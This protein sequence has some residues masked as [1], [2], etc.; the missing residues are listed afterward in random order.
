[1]T[2]IRSI[3]AVVPSVRTVE[4]GGFPVRRPFPTQK[5]PLVDPFLLLDEMGPVDWAPGRAIGAPD[6]PHRGFETVTY[7]LEGKVVHRDSHG[8]EAALGPGDVQWMTAGSGVVHSEMPDRE[9][10]KGGGVM[11]GFQIWVNLPRDKKMMAPR[12]QDIPAD[13][14]PVV[15]DPEKQVRVRVIAGEVWGTRAA[16]QTEIPITYWHVTLEPGASFAEKI[17]AEQNAFFYFV[18]GDAL[19]GSE[20]TNAKSGDLVLFSSDGETVSLTAGPEGADVLVLAA[21]PL[22]EPVARYGP[23]VMNTP[24]EIQ[25]AFADYQSGKMG[26]IPPSSGA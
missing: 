11:H 13:E 10:Q 6:H 12:Y 25:Q 15:F 8:H 14:S 3:Q 18:S 21:T 20:Q 17:P 16:L 9:F 5:L 2:N 1:M 19:V 7:L 22:N 26:R 23:F 24:E 4:G